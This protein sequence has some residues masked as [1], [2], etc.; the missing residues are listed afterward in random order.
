MDM[1]MVGMKVEQM[2]MMRVGMKVEMK[3]GMMVE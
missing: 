2:D 3:V 1:L